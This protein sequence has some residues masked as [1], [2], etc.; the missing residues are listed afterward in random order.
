LATFDKW[1]ADRDG[2]TPSCYRI[3]LIVSG[4]ISHVTTSYLTS[5]NP[6]ALVIT[7]KFKWVPKRASNNIK[8]IFK[9]ISK[10]IS[11]C[12]FFNRKNRLPTGLTPSF[13]SELRAE[14]ESQQTFRFATFLM[15][16]SNYFLVMG[17]AKDSDT[18]Q[19]CP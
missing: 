7:A 1:K 4:I 19:A 17:L 14:N 3:K 13:L 12:Y 18:R 11:I 6:E 15:L 2:G 8:S 9:D 10:S 16:K 5:C